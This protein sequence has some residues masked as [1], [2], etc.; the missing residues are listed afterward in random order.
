MNN[1][2]Q[3]GNNLAEIRKKLGYKVVDFVEKFGM[4]YRTYQT[5]ERGERKPPLE[6]FEQL[7]EIFNVNL[8]Y[9][10]TGK[11]EMF[12]KD[13]NTNTLKSKDN[14]QVLKNFEHFGARLNEVQGELGYLDKAMA[15]IMGTDEKR[16]MKI[17]LGKEDATAQELARLASK[18]DVS[19]DWLMFGE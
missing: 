15:R 11:G 19:I 17:K 4:Q 2:L 1:L 6:F 8:N 16:Y 3:I 14:E 12:L 9:I 5:Y 10:F 18:V 13:E 7:N